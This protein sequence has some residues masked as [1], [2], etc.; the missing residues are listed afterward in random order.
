MNIV[1]GYLKGFTNFIE[2]EDFRSFLLFTLTSQVPSN[3]LAQIGLGG[4]KEII[5]LPYNP[6]FKIYYQKINLISV[7]S[8]IIYIKNQPISKN[9]IIEK[10]DPLIKNYLNPNETS[11]AFR[12]NEKFI[13]PKISDCS[14][15]NS[16]NNSKITIKIDDLFHS[17]ESFL[18]VGEPN[19]LFVIHSKSASNPDLIFTFNMLPE[20]PMK[21]DQK[22]LKLDVYL[23]YEHKTKGITYLKREENYSI[24]YLK[25]IKEVSHA[26][27]Y[28]S[29]FALLLHI[30]S[31]NTP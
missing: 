10:D 6:L 15:F 30:K 24:T 27:L 12:G 11:L 5:N 3:I 28:K 9:F 23:D 2:L 17:L 22:V 1:K 4:P 16:D 29:S 18:A 14:T 8:L 25:D 21:F 20:I 7:G 26:E 19:L 31:L 13:L